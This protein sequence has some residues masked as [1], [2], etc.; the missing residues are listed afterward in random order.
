MQRGLGRTTIKI[1]HLFHILLMALFVESAY[2][3]YRTLKNVFSYQS[4]F[5][6]SVFLASFDTSCYCRAEQNPIYCIQT[7]NASDSIPSLCQYRAT[8]VPNQI[9]CIQENNRMYLVQHGS[10]SV[11]ARQVNWALDTCRK[12]LSCLPKTTEF[13]LCYF[14]RSS[15]TVRVQI[16]AIWFIFFEADARTFKLRIT[17]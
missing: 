10:G 11:K 6:H 8:V 2:L 16:N 4:D 14:E 13:F 9:Y 17:A 12:A 1:F 5:Q 7:K 15:Q 3:S